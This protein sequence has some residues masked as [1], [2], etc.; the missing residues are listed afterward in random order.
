M[1]KSATRVA[2]AIAIGLC[3]LG[4]VRVA[5]AQCQVDKV[6]A[7]AGNAHVGDQYGWSVAVKGDY[8]VVGADVGDGGGSTPRANTGAAF[9]LRRDGLNWVEIQELVANDGLA[10]F[11]DAFGASVAISENAELIVVG[12]PHAR[13][14]LGTAGAAYLFKRYQD[15]FP[16]AADADCVSVGLTSCTNNACDGLTWAVEVKL[17]A[18][19]PTGGDEFGISVDVSGDVVVVGAHMHKRG[20]N[21]PRGAAYVFRLYRN[22]FPC[23]TAVDCEFAGFG[24]CMPGQF[25]CEGVGW[26]Q[27]KKLIPFGTSAPLL[28]GNSVSIEED[29]I[30]VGGRNL[31]GPGGAYIFERVDFVWSDVQKLTAS[32]GLPSDGFGQAVD[33]HGETLVV[34]A[35]DADTEAALTA[36]KAYVYRQVGGTFGGERIL[37]ASNGNNSDRFGRSA[38]LHGNN[39]LIGAPGFGVGSAYLFS[40]DGTNWNEIEEIQAADR[41]EGDRFGHAVSLSETYAMVGAHQVDDAG[42]NA[43]AAYLLAIGLGRDCND[44]LLPDDCEVIDQTVADDNGNGSPDVCECQIAGD[45]TGGDAC[46][47]PFCDQDGLCDLSILAGFCRIRGVCFVDGA[48][49][50][51][52]SCRM[53]DSMVD[54]LR[55]TPIG[56]SPPCEDDAVECTVD[57]C[58]FGDCVHLGMEDCACGD[59]ADT[60]CSL[61]DIFNAEGV[62]DANHLPAGTSCAYDGN[63]CTDDVC[64]GVGGCGVNR[65]AGQS[66]PDDGNPCTRNQCDGAGHCAASNLPSGVACPD[67]SNPC[68]EGNLCDGAGKCGANDLPAGTPC[69]DDGITCTDDV[70]DGAGICEHLNDG[71]QVCAGTVLSHQKISATQGGFTGVVESADSFGNSIASL[72]DFDGDG[73]GDLAVGALG[74]DDG[75]GYGG[76]VWLQFLKADG[77]V[78]SHQ[79]ISATQGGFTG[80]LDV[81]DFFGTSVVS[82]GDHDGDGV[83]DLAVGATGDDDGGFNTNRGAVWLLFLNADGTVKSHQK[84]SAIEGGFTGTLDKRAAFGSSVASLGDLDGDGVGDLAVGAR[85]DSDGGFEVGAVWVLFLKT[86]GTVKSHQKINATE[87]GFVGALHPNDQFGRSTASLGDINGDGVNDLAVGESPF[88]QTL[89]E[90]TVWVLFLN[91]DGTVK[92]HRKIGA[93]QGGFTGTL[94]FSD[95][96]GNSVAGLG[97][98]DGDGTGDLAVAASGDDDGG[99]GRGAVWVLFLN[100]DGTVKLHQKISDAQ[101]GFTGML[102]NSD[103]F[104]TSMAPLGDLDGNGVGD[105]AVAASG[106]DDGGSGRGAIWVLFL[107]GAPGECFGA[108]AGTPCTGNG[109][110]CR[111]NICDGAGNCGVKLPVGSPCPD[112]GNPCTDDV[113]NQGGFCGVNNLPAGTVCLDDNPCADIVCDG[114]GGCAVNNLPKGAACPDDGSL[115]ST[116]LCDG[117]GTCE[118]IGDGTDSCA[119]RVKSQQ[120]ISEVEGGFT[121]SIDDFA[122]FGNAVVSLGDLDGDGV[123]DLAVG[124][125]GSSNGSFP[126]A[127]WVLFLNTDGTVK[128]HQK[129]GVNEGGFTGVLND[130]VAFGISLASLGDLDGDGVVDLAVGAMGDDGQGFFRGA[131]WVLFLNTDGTVKRHQKINEGEGGFTGRLGNFHAFGASLALLGDLDGDGVVDLAVGASGDLDGQRGG[132]VWVL[133]LNSDGTVKAHHRIKTNDFEFPNA[134]SSTHGFGFALAFLGDIDG[135]GVGDLA[136]GTA[137]ELVWVLFLNNDGTVKSFRKIS[138]TE[139]GFAGLV[140]WGDEFGTSLAPL[141]DI[142]DDGVGDLVVG[143]PCDN[144][145]GSGVVWVL[146]LKPDGTVKKHQKISS[147]EGGFTDRQFG[148]GRLG[149]SL[150]RMRDLN[151]DGVVDLAVGAIWAGA[152]WVLFLD[153]PPGECFEAIAGTPCTDDGHPCTDSVCDGAGHCGVNLPEGTVCPDNGSPCRDNVCNGVGGCGVNLPLGT[154]CPD[155]G[156]PCTDNVCNWAGRCGDDLPLGTG[157]PEDGD[158]CTDDVCDGAGRC[159]VNNLIEGTVCPADENPCKENTCDGVG[160]CVVIDLPEGASCPDEGDACTDDF[161]DGAGT[162]EHFDDGISACPGKVKSHQKISATQGGFTGVLDRFDVFG[163]SVAGLADLDGDGVGDLAVGASLDDDGGTDRGAVWILFLNTNGTVRSHQKISST[164]GGFTGTVDD[165]D[166]FG[167]SVASMGDLDGDGVGDLAVG[168]NL[169]DDGG[170]DRG[171]VWILFLN[172]DGTVKS[173]QKISVNQGGFIDALGDGDTFGRSVASLGDL[174]GDGAGDIAVGAVG[175]D[176][177]GADRGAVWVLFLN[178]DGTVKSHQKISDTLGGFNGNLVN[179]DD[180]GVSLASLGDFD[181]DGVGDLAVGM[182][183]GDD[184]GLNRGAVWLLFLNADGTVKAHQGISDTLGDF[185]GSLDNEDFFGSSVDSLGDLDGDGVADLAV[186]MNGDDDGGFRR[187]AVSLLFLNADGT[188]KAHRKIS[189]TAGEFA[190]PLDDAD[191]FGS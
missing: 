177:G 43:G 138:T 108:A 178:V 54:R 148:S 67:E 64:D 172:T 186:G 55:F 110:P 187:G 82:I 14:N 152:V 107:D 130:E 160:G 151:G 41:E 87:G 47:V 90:L 10:R 11:G 15:S 50:P 121:G 185:D 23:E 118:H 94:S 170:Q 111:E 100:T 60:E 19:D 95:G 25:V 33:L 158:L 139:G 146:F 189:A 68:S 52:N 3:L 48:T 101:G 116:D 84:I 140:E 155:D 24:P 1:K 102:D 162:C 37:T 74:D 2:R 78:K 61:P 75:S 179:G 5:Q 91:T 145:S 143:A 175:D 42:Q 153:G 6:T 20:N 129:I 77:S 103:G 30:V 117:A 7:S 180:F 49:N 134:T 18:N 156:N 183:G 69:T 35:A 141:G 12:A 131:V 62:C 171:A 173:H 57:V 83:G 147:T 34:T 44:N 105:L 88:G 80:T 112:D 98:L 56:G 46:S 154:A 115:C 8:A 190:G 85:G 157:C 86:D 27:E 32:D 16:C 184:G 124:S 63:P 9:L 128:S 45:C 72:G 21:F 165:F 29:R 161:C 36:G 31:T 4:S 104:G 53:C 182:T 126:G 22:S 79:K 66:C 188:V 150:A 81:G 26:G 70:C 114:V 135:D 120:E 76:A 113:C 181:G 164:V 176:D 93:N 71:A 28:F 59:P 127:V 106:D 169:D 191:F 174:D 13:G 122:E 51:D 92:S 73:V 167:V 144:R 38:S 99:S 125:V 123:S 166:L 133:F 39:L 136:V 96:F 119:G 89:E 159:G 109:H 65:S 40:F 168:A 58:E 142:D 137:R 163:I 132:A 97:D 17:A 149:S